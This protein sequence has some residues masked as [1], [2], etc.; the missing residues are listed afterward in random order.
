MNA[1]T[2][3]NSY[4]TPLSVS[5]PLDINDTI[6]TNRGHT[7]TWLTIALQCHSVSHLILLGVSK[8]NSISNLGEVS[9][10]EMACASMCIDEFIRG[11]KTCVIIEIVI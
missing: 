10:W 5:D 3:Y 9:V 6:F 2:Q 11:T 1:K 7:G 4:K 8:F